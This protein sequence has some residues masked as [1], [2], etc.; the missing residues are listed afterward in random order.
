MKPIISAA[1][2]DSMLA[3]SRSSILMIRLDQHAIRTMEAPD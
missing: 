1:V 3:L 2:L